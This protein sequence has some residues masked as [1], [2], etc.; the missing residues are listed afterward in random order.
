MDGAMRTV[1]GSSTRM[2]GVFETLGKKIKEY[3]Y[4]FTGSMMIYRAIAW[5]REGITAIKDIDTALTE[6]KKVTDATEE[7][8]EKF[9]DTAA[10]TADKVGSTIKDVVSSTADWARLG[11][12]LDKTS[13]SPLI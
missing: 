8:Y 10:K 11:S 4:Y 13:T 5:V 6:L 3:S 9:L 12:V 7:S 2:M 1:R